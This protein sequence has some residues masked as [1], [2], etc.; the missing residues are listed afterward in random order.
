MRRDIVR[1]D[2]QVPENY[3]NTS[4]DFQVLTRLLTYGLNS[5]KFDADTIKYFNV[6]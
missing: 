5:S 3:I 2:E 4:R 1:W 6:F